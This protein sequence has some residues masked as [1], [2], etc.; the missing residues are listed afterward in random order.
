[1]KIAAILRT[2]FRRA[3]N[4]ARLTR[5]CTRSLLGSVSRAARRMDAPET[6]CS[7]HR[8]TGCSTAHVHS[9]ST[10]TSRH[11]TA[12]SGW[13]TCTTRSTCRETTDSGT[14]GTA[15]LPQVRLHT[16]LT[17]QPL[18]RSATRSTAVTRQ[19]KSMSRQLQWVRSSPRFILCLT[20]T[21]TTTCQL[22]RSRATNCRS[23]TTSCHSSSVGITKHGSRRCDD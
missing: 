23:G 11:P 17:R 15:I 16:T 22:T 1:M 3:P 19:L 21:R 4:A 7:R 13:E 5:K 8:T 14:R 20:R 2:V 9:S 10:L 12:V 6:Q 18:R